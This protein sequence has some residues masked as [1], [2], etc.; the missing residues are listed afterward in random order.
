MQHGEVIIHRESKKRDTKLLPI[1]SQVLSLTY[2]QNT[3]ADRLNGKFPTNLYLS[4]PSHLKYV[5][6][7]P[8]EM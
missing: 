8:C 6:T 5:A 2:F 3:F 4:I 1:T 7:L